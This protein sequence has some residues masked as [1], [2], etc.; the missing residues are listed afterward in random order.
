MK[1]SGK[2]QSLSK[3][4]QKELEMHITEKDEGHEDLVEFNQ[5]KSKELKQIEEFMH[6]LNDWV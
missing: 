3:E 5:L 1:E 2:L 4:W 6:I